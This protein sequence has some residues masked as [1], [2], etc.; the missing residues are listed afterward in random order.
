MVNRYNLTENHLYEYYEI[1]NTRTDHF[2]VIYK[3]ATENQ[4]HLKVLKILKK[5]TSRFYKG[6]SVWLMDRH[7]KY[8]IALGNNSETARILYGTT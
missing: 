1:M 5:N 3:E 8:L 2:I 6:D 4:Y 7:L